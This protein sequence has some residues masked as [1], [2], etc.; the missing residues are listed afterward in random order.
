MKAPGNVAESPAEMVD[1]YP[2]LAEVCGLKPP[3][4]IAG[5]SL[6]EVLD[7]PKA[8][9]R[10]EALTQFA[11]GYSIST[12]RYRYTEWGKDGADGNE[13]YDHQTD[14]EEMHNL[15]G[16]PARKELISELSSRLQKR[17][18]EAQAERVTLR[19]NN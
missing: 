1:F 6:A 8:A 13:L 18:A 16:D 15:A 17:V 12:G 3:A 19:G 14:P 4:H 5:T 2:T 9:P 7:N 10:S 11:S